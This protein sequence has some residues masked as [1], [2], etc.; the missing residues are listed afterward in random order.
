M[1]DVATITVTYNPDLSILASQLR[2]LPLNR[3][4]II[5]DNGSRSSTPKA[6]ERLASSISN[7][8]CIANSENRGLAAAINQGAREVA[9][10]APETRFLFFLDQDS[11]PEA[12]CMDV[13]LSAFDRLTEQ[14]IRVGCIGTNLID[15][16]TGL[17]HGFH[18]ATAWRWRRVYPAAESDSPVPCANLNGSGTLV[19]LALFLEFGGLDESLFIDHVDTEWSFR[20]LAAGFRIWGIPSARMRHRMGQGSLC[21]WWFGWRLWPAR[22]PLRHRYLFRNAFLLLRRPYVPR[23]WKAWAIAKLSLTLLAHSL[24]DPQRGAQVKAMIGGMRAALNNKNFFYHI[25]Y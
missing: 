3:L 12:G 6:I 17:S 25:F 22:S 24:F 14:G 1:N 2:S 8:R 10:L 16:A 18:Q 9:E 20:V 19:P 23:V 7:A 4:K 13:L 11:E 21:Y 5:I 15:A